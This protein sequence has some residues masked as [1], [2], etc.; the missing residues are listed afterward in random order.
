MSTNE[1]LHNFKVYMVR[2]NN[3][4]SKNV[5]LN[6]ENQIEASNRA[7]RE[8]PDYTVVDVKDRGVLPPDHRE[9]E[10]SLFL[11]FRYTT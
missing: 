7:I 3:R 6:A 10:A 1:P 4:I 9:A 2:R 11:A 5:M 8:N